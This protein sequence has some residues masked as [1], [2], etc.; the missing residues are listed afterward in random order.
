MIQRLPTRRAA[1]ALACVLIA[2]SGCV[3]SP[4]GRAGKPSTTSID[5]A[6]DPTPRAGKAAGDPM[7]EYVRSAAEVAKQ[8]G[9]LLGAAA[10]LS[11]LYD[12][13]PTDRD[14]IF[15]LARHMRYIGA[16]T[17]AEQVLNDG[18]AIHSRDSLLRLELAKVFVASGRADQA[19]EILE[20]LRVELPQDPSILQALGVARDRLGQ[21]DAAKEAYRQ[22]IALGR[23]SAALLSN[24]AMSYLLSGDLAEAETFLRKAIVAPGATPQVRQNLALTLSLRGQVQAATQLSAETLPRPLATSAVT[25]YAMIP[26]SQTDNSSS[27]AQDPWSLAAAAQ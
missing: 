5:P 24:V 1:T 22:A 27:M 18:L 8:D 25:A 2:L 17:E 10:H 13:T 14:V 9:K 15:D 20:I 7:L 19:S 26:A 3:A 4:E 11:R 21:H 23:P 16:L 6:Y 12:E